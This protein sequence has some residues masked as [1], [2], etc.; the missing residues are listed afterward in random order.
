MTRELVGYPFRL[1]FLPFRVDASSELDGC[2]R[3]ERGSRDRRVCA[4]RLGMARRHVEEVA[5][6][7]RPREGFGVRRSM[8]ISTLLRTGLLI[9]LG[10]WVLT[11]HDAVAQSAR[12]TTSGRSGG[13][14]GQ[15]R[16]PAGPSPRNPTGPPPTD[17][18]GPPPLY[19][20]GP[21]PMDPT[22]PPPGTLGGVVSTRPMAAVPGRDVVGQV[23][24]RGV[25]IPVSASFYCSQ[26][27]RG[28]GSRSGFEAHVS[29]EHGETRNQA[30]S[31]LVQDGG[32]WT[33]H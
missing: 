20:T 28:F 12:D 22:G 16:N 33:L 30:F 1:G 13:L 21:P 14:L 6:A 29:S 5:F 31:R 19:P 27:N 11:A 17:P 3:W 10:A 8:C 23:E 26:H 2:R 25:Q 4:Y 24:Q 18:T 15:L 32:V 7:P 9:G